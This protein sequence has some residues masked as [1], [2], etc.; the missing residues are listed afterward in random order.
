MLDR[1]SF[2]KIVKREQ[3][4]TVK[5]LGGQAL[6]VSHLCMQCSQV[7]RGG[8]DSS[9]G[10]QRFPFAPFRIPFAKGSNTVSRELDSLSFLPFSQRVAHEM[11]SAL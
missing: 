11:F 5:R 3:K 8:Q 6:L 7:P 2:R 9:K 4:L 1:G 10:E